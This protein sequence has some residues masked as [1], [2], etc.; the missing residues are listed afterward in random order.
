MQT[1]RDFL[2]HAAALTGSAFLS[3]V[4]PEAIARAAAIDPEADTTFLDAE[5]VVILMQ[6]NRSFDHC[7]GALQGVRGFRDPRV[8]VQPNGMPV[9]FQSDSKGNTYSP[10]RLDIKNSNATWIGGLPHS[11]QDQVDARNEGKYDKWLVAKPRAGLPFT[12]GHYTREDLPFYYAFADAFTVCDQAF[13]SSLTGTTPNRLYLWTGTIRENSSSPARVHNGDTDYDAEAAWVTFPE[14]LED[15]GVNWRVYQNEI[16]LD[17][18]LR[19]EEDAWLSNFTDNPLEWFSQYGV[20][21]AKSRMTH[22]ATR[23]KALPEEIEAKRKEIQANP[24]EAKPKKE[25]EALEIDLRAKLAESAEYT[26]SAWKGQTARARSLHRNAFASNTADPDYRSL[27]TLT[28]KDAENERELLVPKGDVLHQLR[29]DVANG[30][31]PTVSWIVAPE[32]FSDHPGSAWYGAWYLSE[33]LHILTENPEVWKKTIFILC[34]DENDGYFDHVPPYVAPFPNKPETGKV[35]EG[36]D[37]TEDVSDAHGRTHSIGLG[38]RCPLVVASPWSRGGC[39]NS[40]VFDHTSVLRFMEVWLAHKG[41]PVVESNIS[42]WRRT[43]CGD[44][45]SVFRPFA[46]DRASIPTPLNRDA[47]LKG[48]Y[49]AKFRPNPEGGAPLSEEQ[50]KSVRVGAAQ[51]PG[52]R[53]SCPLPYEPSLNARISEG[54]LL[55]T[56]TAGNKRFGNR[57]QGIPFNAYSYGS[58]MT[59]RSYAVR[60]GAMVSDQWPITGEYH[61]RFDGPNGFCREF[62]GTAE[63]GVRILVTEGS[64]DMVV[65]VVN[66]GA[67]PI[68]VEIKDE[69]Y[70]TPVQFAKLSPLESKTWSVNTKRGW[71]DFSVAAEGVAYRYSGRLETG[72]WG[73]TDPAMG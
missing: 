68:D 36:I 48:I 7:Y 58:E 62:R 59:S 2:R 41:K 28:Y 38:Y 16:S 30:K 49:D 60:A 24:E 5:H 42:A 25:L 43:V 33:V 52:T 45:T 19:G 37:T 27:E 3:G 56:M 20:R 10:F 15:A 13:C 44:L 11:W 35:S 39:V 31:L 4:V 63:K 47:T 72:E 23:L 46:E 55:V 67:S 18:G 71:Y 26:E 22:V 73:I 61:L 40:Q 65:E 17:S 53:P 51:E 8:H 29:K 32:H 1:R 70:G 34:Y 9:W 57:S 54:I 64:R 14:R 12:L 21:F 66:D 69:S 50:V 6:E